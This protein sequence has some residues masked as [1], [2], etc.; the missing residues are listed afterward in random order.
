VLLSWDKYL[1]LIYLRLKE[2]W[3][4]RVGLIAYSD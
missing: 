2:F 3:E 4:M 1:L